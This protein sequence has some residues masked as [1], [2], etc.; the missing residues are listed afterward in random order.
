M[1][2]LYLLL[3]IIGVHTVN[4]QHIHESLGRNHLRGIKRLRIRKIYSPTQVELAQPK[5]VAS[6]MRASPLPIELSRPQF[7]YDRTRIKKYFEQ[8]S[9]PR[10]LKKHISTPQ[11]EPIHKRVS[12]VPIPQSSQ[13]ALYKARLNSYSANFNNNTITSAQLP[14]SQVR[15]PVNVKKERKILPVARAAPIQLLHGPRE[16]QELDIIEQVTIAATTARWRKIGP[17]L[18]SSDKNSLQQTQP[19]TKTVPIVHP[20]AWTHPTI[21]PSTTVPPTTERKSPF[22]FVMKRR[23][24]F[25]RF[26]SGRGNHEAGFRRAYSPKIRGLLHGPVLEPPSEIEPLGKQLI[27]GD[28]YVLGGPENGFKEG[29]NIVEDLATE[30]DYHHRGPVPVKR[31]KF[32]NKL[33]YRPRLKI[34]RPGEQFAALRSNGHSTPIE[35]PELTPFNSPDTYSRRGSQDRDPLPSYRITHAPDYTRRI[36]PFHRGPLRQRLPPAPISLPPPK[37]IFPGDTMPTT[38]PT[39]PPPP[40]TTPPPP[41]PTTTTAPPP[42][43]PPPPQTEASDAGDSAL[44]FGDIGT[45][46]PGFGQE[47]LLGGPSGILAGGGSGAIPTTPPPPPPPPPTTTTPPPPPPTTTTPPP[48]PPTTTTPPPP[49]PTTTTPIPP[50]SNEKKEELKKGKW[51]GKGKGKQNE[52]FVEIE[53]PSR[54]IQ[55]QEN[56]VIPEN[57]GL[58]A[59]TPPKEFIGG[60]GTA[61]KSGGSFGGGFGG[62]GGA[63]FGGGSGGGFGGGSGGGFGGGS[64]GSESG[65][66]SEPSS[67]GGEPAGGE[68]AEPEG[69]SDADF[70]TGDS[71]FIPNKSG[72]TGDGYGPPLFPGEAV[73]PPVPETVNVGG[74]AAGIPPPTYNQMMVR[75]ENNP[76]TVKPSALLSILSRADQGFNQ[77]LKHFEEGTP[78]ETA[79]I[80]ILEVA[81]GSQKL[82][83]QAKLL[84]H[85]DRT[86]GLDNLQRLQRWANTGGAFDLLKEEFVKLAKN[87]KPPENAIPTLPPQFEYLLAPSG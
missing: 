75:E 69:P 6:P 15:L 85:V 86:F 67:P 16:R 27:V 51:N 46:P 33:T 30:P 87:F 2:L 77:A 5:H 23:N 52:E 53:P 3:V 26:K 34:R 28:K 47:F 54:P 60:F 36:L 76:T 38:P 20:V 44:G 62:G 81:L 41:P 73:P 79:A 82:D 9:K 65:L 14:L 4:A 58:R 7:S 49:P 80:D 68:P 21:P 84:G 83:S 43:P 71:G 64:G 12:A 31:F 78:V 74:A 17:L 18:G 70:F 45:P 25:E 13:E 48:P 56:F 10:G 24:T 57:S 22:S 29:P 19:I 1:N 37:Q 39:P 66:G 40:P 32:T 50:A 61:G 59:A 72:P 63:G 35:I 8:V 55:P 11:V 42:P